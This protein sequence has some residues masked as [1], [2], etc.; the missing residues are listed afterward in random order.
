MQSDSS[1]HL[2]QLQW[3]TYNYLLLLDTATF[4]RSHFDREY[5]DCCDVLCTVLCTLFTSDICNHNGADWVYWLLWRATYNVMYPS[6]KWY[7]RRQRSRLSIPIAVT[8]YV[9]CYVPFLQVISA[10]ITVPISS[11]I[12][13]T[14]MERSPLSQS[15]RQPIQQYSQYRGNRYNNTLNIAASDTTILSI[16]QQPIQQYSQY[17]SDG[18]PSWCN[19]IVVFICGGSNEIHTI[20]CYFWMLRLSFWPG[21]YRLLWCVMYGVMYHFLQVIFAT[22][23]VPI[24]ST[25]VPNQMERMPRSQSVRQPIQQY[26]QYRSDGQLSYRLHQR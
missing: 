13:P 12:V 18:N 7:L 26:C 24:S 4:L 9:Q 23:T 3:N 17:R 19:L 11:K 20:I 21:V 16:S 1:F 10:T 5:T 15:V 22:T 2:P 8:C 6:Y 25:I 14:Q